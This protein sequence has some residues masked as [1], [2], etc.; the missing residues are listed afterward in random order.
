MGKKNKGAAKS[1]AEQAAAQQAAPAN[2]TTQQQNADKSQIAVIQLGDL[3][4][5]AQTRALSGLD[6]NHTVDLLKMMH[7]TYRTDPAAAQKLGLPQDTVDKINKITAI[8]QVAILTNEIMIAQTPFAVA[9]RVSQLEAIKEVAPMLGVTID[10]K[11]LPAPDAQGVVELPSDAVKV[12]KEAQKAVKEE[13]AAAAEK[14]ELDPTKIDSEENL[15]KS[16]LNILVKGNGSENLYDKIATAINFYEA[17]L[18]IQAGKSEDPESARAAL[19]D[20]SRVDLLS[21]IAHL[22]GKCTFTIG[23][24]ARFMYENTER[25]KSPVVAFCT[26]RDASLN[27]KTGMPQIEDQLVADIVKVLIRWYA[28]TEIAVTNE[29]VA[30]FERDIK[31]LEKDAKKNAKGIEDGKKK[32]EH[33]KKH[34]EDVEKVVNYV[35]LPGRETVDAFAEDYQDNKREGFKMARMIG[36]KIAKTYYGDVAIKEIKM[37]SLVHNL[38]Q[39]MGVITNMFLPPLNRIMDYSEANI[40]ELEKA[41]PAAKD[42]DKPSEEGKNE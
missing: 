28:D 22:L 12:S 9:M 17:Y 11:A 6:P 26:L 16:L 38:Q 20:K 3:D 31:V 40:T 25:T 37:E 19:K 10:T 7:E 18:G 41:E 33:A 15:K 29:V 21:E 42:D 27:K 4:K 36:S 34:L 23:G 35:N 39:Y 5:L 8:G 13:Q 30:G 24:I 1:A 32:I 2:K 14:V